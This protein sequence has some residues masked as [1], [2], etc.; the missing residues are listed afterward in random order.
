LDDKTALTASNAGIRLIALTTILNKGDFARLRQYIA[1]NY[2]AGVLAETPVS[3]RLAELKAAHRL[4]GKLRVKQV[5]AADKHQVIAAIESE[6]GSQFIARV[7][8]EEDYPHKVLD[9]SLQPI[10]S[11]K[12]AET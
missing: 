10:S 11:E 12:E 9:Y 1:D 8:V 3:M 2:H 7:T 6:R 4:A 5:I